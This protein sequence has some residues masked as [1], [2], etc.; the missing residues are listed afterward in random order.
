MS[1]TRDNAVTRMSKYLDDVD[2]VDASTSEAQDA[3]KTA[4]WETYLQAS[5]WAPQ[6][7]QTETTVTTSSAGVGDL[8]SL[9]PVRILA[10]NEYASGT[11]YPIPAASLSD[12]PTN[13]SGVRTLKVLYLPALTF[14]SSGSAEFAWG[15]S[16]IDLPF[17]DDLMC[18]KAAAKLTVFLDRQNKQLEREIEKA[19]QQ[20][21]RLMNL[22]T[23]RVMPLRGRSRKSG[24]AYVMT[25]AVSLQIVR[26]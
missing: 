18:L 17:L 15:Q 12:G 10:V 16:G 19:T 4:H 24:L 6:R 2:N 8:S 25:D 11:R 21:Q 1:I 22:S 9:D 13:V 3:L 20:A 26:V 7:F 23:W 14:P 5:M